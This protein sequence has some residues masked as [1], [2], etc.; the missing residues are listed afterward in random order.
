M[1]SSF[2]FLL[3]RA[4]ATR[5]AITRLAIPGWISSGRTG[6]SAAG[7]G[8]FSRLHLFRVLRHGAGLHF[9]T[10]DSHSLGL[11]K[12]RYPKGGVSIKHGPF[13][14]LRLSVEEGL[15]GS[16]VD[17]TVPLPVEKSC[18]NPFLNA[19][20]PHV[21]FFGQFAHGVSVLESSRDST[22]AHPVPNPL[23]SP[24]DLFGDL[25]HAHV[26]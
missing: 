11:H 1:K 15:Q 13:Q 21:K 6:N 18:F 7:R 24:L 14:N 8:S 23:L 4:G 16:F 26:V 3:P 17:P 19:H 10:V 22:L 20:A 5:L 25:P 2:R 12:L 9:S